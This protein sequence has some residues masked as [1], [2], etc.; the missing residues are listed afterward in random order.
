VLLAYI[1]ATHFSKDKLKNIQVLGDSKHFSI[2]YS[3]NEIPA[4]NWNAVWESNFEPIVIAGR[5]YV[6]A[7]F[8]P[9][10]PDYEYELVIEPKMSFGTAHH[11]TTSMM[12][13]LMLE[14]DLNGNSL[15]DMGC[16]T[17]ILAIMAHKKGAGDIVAIDNDEWAFENTKENMVKNKTVIKAMLGDAKTIA[18]MKFDVVLANI[19][20][21]I[22]LNDIPTYAKSINEKG[23]LLLSG[24][25]ENDLAAIRKKAEEYG[26]TYQKHLLNNDWV[27]VIF[28]K[29]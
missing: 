16:G 6:R 9:T 18:G 25:Y 7:P 10:K 4:Q 8:H 13:Q 15:L 23:Q 14:L 3:I 24:F 11:E 17:G 19:N 27:A 28:T 5:C 12:I 2:T 1:P 26:L 20:R 21:N 29:K 22:L